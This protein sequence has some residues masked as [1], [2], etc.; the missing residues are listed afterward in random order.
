MCVCLLC[1][2]VR[3]RVHICILFQV[4]RRP[5]G[6]ASLPKVI[7]AFQSPPV[8]MATSIAPNVAD[9]STTASSYKPNMQR[10]STCILT[11]NEKG[12]GAEFL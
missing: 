2:L 11:K 12:I 9:S 3:V 10:I 5:K 1:T 6:N 7:S 8:E 4:V